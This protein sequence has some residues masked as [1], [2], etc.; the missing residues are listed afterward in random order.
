MRRRAAASLVVACLVIGCGDNAGPDAAQAC[1]ADCE[2]G[3]GG[4]C[5][6]GYCTNRLGR[7]RQGLC[8]PGV[9]T[10][11]GDSGQCGCL[12]GTCDDRM[13]CVTLD[14][15]IARPFTPACEFLDAAPILAPI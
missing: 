7:R 15:A 13:C 1:V 3:S 11:Y 5:N 4:N 9:H 14:G 12:T 2:C 6:L 8:S 10:E